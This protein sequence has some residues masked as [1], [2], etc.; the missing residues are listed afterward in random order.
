MR[1]VRRRHLGL[2]HGHEGRA[3]D[4]TGCCRIEDA[5]M[6][7]RS[8]RNCGSLADRALLE[9][10]SGW[11]KV[12][13]SVAVIALFSSSAAFAANKTYRSRAAFQADISPPALLENFDNF[14]NG[15][16]VA[17]L[18]G[19]L[20]TFDSPLPTAIFGGW[21]SGEFSGGGL[22]PEPRFQGSSLTL[23]FTSPVFG[24]GANAFDDFD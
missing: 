5:A 17:G 20:V 6:V 12:F 10:R 22:T 2:G 9:T 7:K 23:N 8:I 1:G 4:R 3:S 18:L 14:G 19:G 11:S 13:V 21:G 16:T 15:Q 24:V